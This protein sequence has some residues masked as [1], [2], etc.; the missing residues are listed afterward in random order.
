VSPPIPT[1]KKP[2][3][4]TKLSPHKS[5]TYKRFPWPV[6]AKCG[7]V[8]LKNDATRKRLREGCWEYEDEKP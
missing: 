3:G 6:C 2:E 5:V 1:M 8:Y 4:A 7:L